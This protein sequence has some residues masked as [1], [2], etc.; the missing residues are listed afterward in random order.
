MSC[1]DAR[2]T[3]VCSSLHLGIP[4]SVVMKCTGH[5]DFRAMRPYV[6][7]TDETTVR[8][9]AKWNLQSKK[10]EIDILFDKA[11]EEKLDE[12]IK[13]LRTFKCVDSER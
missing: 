8:E 13:L 12:V 3:F 10:V 4:Q 9:L 2:R 11:N 1:H 7:V 5:S 6:E